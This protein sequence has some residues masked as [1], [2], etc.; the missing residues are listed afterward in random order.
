MRKYL[1]LLFLVLV[2]TT[3]FGNGA[4]GLTIRNDSNKSLKIY[5]LMT[6]FDFMGIEGT[7]YSYLE[8]IVIPP[9]QYITFSQFNDN[10]SFPFCCSVGCDLMPIDKWNVGGLGSNAVSCTSVPPFTLTD[11]LFFRGFKYEVLDY[12]T[13]PYDN[14][15][16]SN[17]GGMYVAKNDTLLPHITDLWWFTVNRDY[18][19]NDPNSPR[20]VDNED[21]DP[22]R[23]PYFDRNYP[24]SSRYEIT[25]GQ[26]EFI[27]TTVKIPLLI[28][29]QVIVFRN[30]Q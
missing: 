9:G 10:R 23:F 16:E 18:D 6:S 5:A 17:Y 15:L 25:S 20:Y 11:F 30:R 2:T 26:Y 24:R 22:L 8:S 27:E 28:Y 29:N 4:R 19:R 21:Y 14:P 12:N 7:Y 1:C 13:P 3:S